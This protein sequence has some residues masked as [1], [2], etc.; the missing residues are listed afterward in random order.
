MLYPWISYGKLGDRQAEKD[1][2]LL[3]HPV[4]ESRRGW[5]LFVSV[6]LWQIRAQ[7]SSPCHPTHQPHHLTI[8]ALS[9]LVIHSFTHSLARSPGWYRIT[10]LL[11]LESLHS[12]IHF[13]C[14]QHIN[15][16]CSLTTSYSWAWPCS[17]LC[18]SCQFVLLKCC[19]SSSRLHLALGRRRFG[20]WCNISGGGGVVCN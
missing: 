17:V 6:K 13:A 9:S 19:S 1:S 2:V 8:R 4:I 16:H 7:T 10:C 11:V 3:P 15:G 5:D 18:N 12:E 20:V 14:Q